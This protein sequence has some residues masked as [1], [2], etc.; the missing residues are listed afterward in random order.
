MGSKDFLKKCGHRTAFGIFD[1]LADK[2]RQGIRQRSATRGQATGVWDSQ[3]VKAVKAYWLAREGQGLHR[4]GGERQLYWD[5]VL[6]K[7]KT[8]YFMLLICY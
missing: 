6:S 2:P 5:V 7:A 1:Y 3:T 8:V 4:Q